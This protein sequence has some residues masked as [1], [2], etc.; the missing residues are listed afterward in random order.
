[1][2]TSRFMRFYPQGDLLVPVLGFMAR[3]NETEAKKLDPVNYSA[4]TEMGKLGVEKHFETILHGQVGYQQVETDAGGR[5][6]R[7]LNEVPPTSGNSLYL[8]VDT[9]LQK[10]SQ[11]ALGDNPGAVV[12]IDPQSG[13]I[14]ALYSNPSYDPNLFVKG[15]S[16]KDYQALQQAHGR[17]L[18]NRAIRGLYAPGS[19]A[20]PYMALE[21][22]SSG[23]IPDGYAIN[24]P[25]FFVLGHHIYRDD[26]K[27]GH[28]VVDVVKAITV[29]CDTF[30][31]TLANKMG[32]AKI[33]HILSAF[34]LE[35][36]SGLKWMKKTA[37]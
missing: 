8:T 17:P 27:G 34:G 24:D 35:N 15:I 10:I 31:Y 30:F 1:M 4:S 36:Q 16:S 9:K 25:G 26:R 19:T 14:L 7:V 28:G 13:E 2:I 21:A 11:D 20:K 29:S 22:L 37:A 18:Y 5:I 33:D 12:A 6:V 3:I 23:S 32:I